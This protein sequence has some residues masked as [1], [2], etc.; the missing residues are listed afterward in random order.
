MRCK[1]TLI[2]Y[3]TRCGQ[4]VHRYPSQ[5][6]RCERAFC[7]RQCHMATLNE[8]LNPSRMT[9]ETREKLRRARLNRGDG[10]TYPKLYGMPEHRVVAERILGRPLKAGEVVHHIDG[11][12]RNNDSKNI[13]V[14]P[15]QA[16]HIRW[17]IEND[18]RYKRRKGG[19]EHDL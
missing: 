5:R 9:D 16:E 8:E 10:K 6:K 17:H 2:E 3:C 13:L 14:F 1:D 19:G 18:P 12:K 11:N 15:S 4:P 7:S